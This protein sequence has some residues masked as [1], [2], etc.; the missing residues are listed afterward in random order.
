VLRQ[1]LHLI[2]QGRTFPV[3]V[4][5]L[6]G[7]SIVSLRIDQLRLPEGWLP[8][9]ALLIA[10]VAW[11]PLVWRGQGPTQRQYHRTLPVHHLLHDLLKVAAGGIWLMAALAVVLMPILV[12]AALREPAFLTGPAPLVW[13]NFFTGPLLVYL[14][15]SCVPLLTHRPLEWML[16]IS[17][18]IVGLLSLAAEY[19]F[20]A[21]Q[22][23]VSGLFTG[24]LSLGRAL[25]GGYLS[26]PWEAHLGLGPALVEPANAAWLIVT[27]LWLMLA[28]AAVCAASRIGG[29]KGS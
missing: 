20:E 6:G 3:M 23:I 22:A 27:A 28:L 5:L 19:R 24:G 8:L 18:G 14:F 10:S 16:G 21:I 12:A 2:D 15:V 9:P 1:Q 13:L 17:A 26:Q 29:R 7:V 4:A 11:A 25:M